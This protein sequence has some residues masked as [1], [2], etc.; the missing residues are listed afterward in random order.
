MTFS[1]N[2]RF[3]VL[4]GSIHFTDHAEFH[5]L[6]GV[7][8]KIGEKFRPPKKVKYEKIL[9]LNLFLSIIFLYLS[10]LIQAYLSSTIGGFVFNRTFL[11]R[12]PGVSFYYQ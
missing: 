3:D 7:E 8:I 6:Q 9:F 2:R 5:S 4:F 12:S 11:N 1:V 10:Y